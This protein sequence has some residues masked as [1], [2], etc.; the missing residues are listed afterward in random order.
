[1]KTTQTINKIIKDSWFTRTQLS[2]YRKM[3]VTNWA[4]GK[5]W[6]KFTKELSKLPW[7][8]KWKWK[9]LLADIDMVSNIH[10]I[11]FYIWTWFI[12]YIKANWEFSYNM[13]RLM[14]WTT[15]LARILLFITLFFGTSIFWVRY[16]NWT[17]KNN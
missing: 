9:K 17:N 6:I 1:M 12:Q 5:W 4:G 3:W 11:R 2:V 13:L 15:V 14:W 8:K 7:F 10:D 16:Y